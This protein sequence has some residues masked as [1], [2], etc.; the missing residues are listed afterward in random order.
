MGK[1]WT[2][3][4]AGWVSN[5]GRWR[6]RGPVFGRTEFWLYRVG[7]GRYTPSGHHDDAVAFATLAEAMHYAARIPTTD[8]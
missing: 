8:S 6:I 1:H 5:D 2:K 4:K 7:A 3:T